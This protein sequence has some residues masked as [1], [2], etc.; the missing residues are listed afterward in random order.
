MRIDLFK[1]YCEEENNLCYEKLCCFFIH[2]F[3]RSFWKSQIF[4]RLAFRCKILRPFVFL[5]VWSSIHSIGISFFAWRKFVDL[6]VISNKGREETFALS[7]QDRKSFAY[8]K[9]LALV[10]PLKLIAVS[11][12]FL[13]SKWIA[14][15]SSIAKKLFVLQNFQT[16]Q[17][18]HLFVSFSKTNFFTP[19]TVYV[20]FLFTWRVHLICC[21]RVCWGFSLD[22][23]GLGFF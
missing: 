23:I 18:S 3:W 2:I 19:K 17:S 13:Y 9:Y 10:W 11:F 14:H 1:S 20:T 12:T 4:Y 16:G 22:T 5:F 6:A 15:N 21:L 8:M 7:L